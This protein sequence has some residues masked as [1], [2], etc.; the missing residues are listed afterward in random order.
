VASQGPVLVEGRCREQA[1]T[2]GREEE[3][4]RVL[5]GGVEVLRERVEDELGESDHSPAGLGLGLGQQAA[6]V[7]EAHYLLL[8]GHCARGEVHVPAPKGE[9]LA[10][11]QAAEAGEEDHRAK[12]HSHRVREFKD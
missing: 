5:A 10:K 7:V 9:E 11:A 8:D 12:S 4:V 1:T 3:R 6:P 2:L